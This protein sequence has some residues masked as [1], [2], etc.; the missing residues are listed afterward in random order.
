MNID[1]QTG[2]MVGGTTTGPAI[3]G[4]VVPKPHICPNC[5]ACPCCGRR[6]YGYQ[7]PPFAPWPGYPQ[8][9]YGDVPMG[10]GGVGTVTCQ[11]S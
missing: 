5:G 11:A 3:G 10:V 6:P 7:P 8:P 2:G 4:Y 1:N 9:Y